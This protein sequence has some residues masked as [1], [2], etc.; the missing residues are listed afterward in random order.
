MPDQ[1]RHDGGE[2]CHPH[3]VMAREDGPSTS[4][5]STERESWMPARL[6]GKILT[7]RAKRADAFAE[8]GNG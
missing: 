2:V 6:V 4:F 3:F 7:L 8:H 5:V 1:V